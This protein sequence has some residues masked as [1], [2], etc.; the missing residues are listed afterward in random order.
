M[1][2][3]FINFFLNDFIQKLYL[4]NNSAPIYGPIIGCCGRAPNVHYFREGNKKLNEI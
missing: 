1:I 3:R 2:F 4:I